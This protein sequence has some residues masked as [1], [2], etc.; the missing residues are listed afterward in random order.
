MGCGGGLCNQAQFSPDRAELLTSAR[1]APGRMNGGESPAAVLRASAHCS[2][3]PH[4]TGQDWTG[5]DATPRL[6]RACSRSVIAC[7]PRPNAAVCLSVRAGLPNKKKHVPLMPADG[8][9]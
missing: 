2:T 6:I 9:R 3:A 1:E 4:C 7:Q 5:R 8:A